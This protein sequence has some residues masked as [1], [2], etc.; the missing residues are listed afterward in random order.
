M[1][2]SL[3]L[4]ATAGWARAGGALPGQSAGRRDSTSLNLRVRAV[5]VASE[6]WRAVRYVF[7]VFWTYWG[8]FSVFGVFSDVFGCV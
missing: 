1:C 2:W 6:M 4:A 8:K 7:V 5:A 3:R